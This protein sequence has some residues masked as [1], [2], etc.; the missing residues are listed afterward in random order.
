MKTITVIKRIPTGREVWRYSA[1]LLEQ[2]G[3]RLLLEAPFN[4]SDTPFMGILIRT[5]DR[6]METYFTDRWYNIFEIHDR[7]DD[8]LKGW[9]CNIGRPAVWEE[10]ATLSYID[11]ALDLWVAPDGSQTVVD[12]EEFLALDLDDDTRAQALAGL[13]ELRNM[14]ARKIAPG[15]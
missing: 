5:G 6:F 9:Y 10:D 12:E 13:A 14:F 4:A 2:S 15:Y 3:G 11:L 7:E 8:R 1:T